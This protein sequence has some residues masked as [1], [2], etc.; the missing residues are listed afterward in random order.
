M[1]G[2][3]SAPIHIKFPEPER[4]GKVVLEL[5]EFSKSYPGGNSA[6]NEVF[7]GTGPLTISRGDKIALI[8]KNG[9]GKSTLSRILVGEEPFAGDR[10]E[11]HNVELTFFAQHQA[12]TL[13]PKNTIIEE[14]ESESR[15][16]SE[17]QIR[18]LLGAFLFTGEDAYKKVGG[19]FRRRKEQG[20]SCKDTSLSQEFYDIG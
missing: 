15:G 8:G 13:D 18:S 20:R 1:P 7:S 12:E 3:H 6:E 10:K 2:S 17:T 14:L 5:S 11:G 9:A 19:A 4:S 16:G